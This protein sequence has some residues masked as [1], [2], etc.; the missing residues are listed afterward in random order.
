MKKLLL[1]LVP[2]FIFAHCKKDHPAPPSTEAMY[3]PPNGTATWETK[4][5]ASLGW[6]NTQL[7]NLYT[8]LQQKNTK[9][10]I[11]LK[12]G[13]IVV[14][15]YFDTFTADSNWYWASAGK[16]VT[17]MLVGIAQ[18]EGH[19]NINNRTSQYLGTGWTSLPVAK[20]NLVSVRHQLT[21]T[22]GLSDDVASLD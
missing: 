7:N 16:T 22:T 20:E 9:A 21:M 11:I 4:S 10:F 5:V 6:D 18:Q 8:F 1:L 12:N 3:F 17:A 14:E 13:R 19:L 15:K 2:V